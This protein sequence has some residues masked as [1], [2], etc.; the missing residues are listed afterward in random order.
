MGG[1]DWN[2]RGDEGMGI[3][4]VEEVESIWAG[5]FYGPGLVEMDGIGWLVGWVKA[6]GLI[7]KLVSYAESDDKMQSTYIPTII[8]PGRDDQEISQW[9]DKPN[10]DDLSKDQDEKMRRRWGW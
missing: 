9:L 4:G 5:G 3:E 1:N 6:M 2:R 8:Q 10:I 7:S